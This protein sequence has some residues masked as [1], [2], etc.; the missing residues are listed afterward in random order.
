M[1]WL[2]PK[3]STESI[4][5]FRSYNNSQGKRLMLAQSAV[6]S[7]VHKTKSDLWCSL[8]LMTL[9]LTILRSFALKH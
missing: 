8:G 1:S 9:K 3:L 2:F 5:Y 4:L 7:L 6:L